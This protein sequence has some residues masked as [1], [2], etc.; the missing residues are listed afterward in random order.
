MFQIN[1]SVEWK[2]NEKVSKKLENKE[3]KGKEAV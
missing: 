1:K 3:K 2:E